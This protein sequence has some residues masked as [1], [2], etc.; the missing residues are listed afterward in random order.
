M[1]YY[2]INIIITTIT[3]N[4]PY[5]MFRSE[6][7]TIRFFCDVMRHG[8]MS[9]TY[10]AAVVCMVCVCVRA[11]VCVYWIVLPVLCVSDVLDLFLVPCKYCVL[12]SSSSTSSDILQD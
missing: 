7:V 4:G 6:Q 9:C 8:L 10:K 3:V 1:F 12:Q 11:C 5:N 2:Y